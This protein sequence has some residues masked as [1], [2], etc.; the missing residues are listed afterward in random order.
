M[1]NFTYNEH[2]FTSIKFC[3][4]KILGNEQNVTNNNKECHCFTTQKM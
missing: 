2:S 4:L 1:N 3:V